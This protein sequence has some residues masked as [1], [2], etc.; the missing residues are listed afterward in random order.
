MPTNLPKCKLIGTDGNVFAIIGNVSTS[1]KKA[2]LRDKADEFTN[3]AFNAES[4][5]HV[6]QLAMNYVDVC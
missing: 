6:L 2:G 1:L 5:D 3:K 4:Y